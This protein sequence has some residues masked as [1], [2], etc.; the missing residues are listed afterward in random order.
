MSE[1]KLALAIITGSNREGRLGDKIAAWVADVARA[2]ERFSIDMIDVAL[3]DLPPDYPA[4]PTAGVLDLRHRINRAAAFV[5]VTPEYNH[6]FPGPLKHALDQAYE[7]WRAKPIAFVSY[8]GV[9]GG[10]RAVEALRLVFAEMQA[11]T[12]RDGLSF[13]MAWAIFDADG[14]T[15]DFHARLAADVMFGQL[16]WWAVALQRART[17]LPLQDY[18][19]ASAAE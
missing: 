11:V 14:G 2:T 4:E 17:E 13:P 16:A 1:K 10:L 6:S 12:I 5:V 19:P 9:S 3:L 7:E 15:P 8:G 18:M